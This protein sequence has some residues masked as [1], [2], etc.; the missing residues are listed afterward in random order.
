MALVEILMR[1]NPFYRNYTHN[2]KSLSDL[3][4]KL[5][6]RIDDIQSISSNNLSFIQRILVFLYA[7]FVRIFSSDIKYY[8]NYKK[9]VVSYLQKSKH[10]V[11]K[12]FLQ[13]LNIVGKKLENRYT[14]I[15]D[16]T[17]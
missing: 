9:N 4:N 3:I 14:R 8:R 11:N 16:E 17:L 2:A 12:K 5:R 10:P 13:L 1:P 6:L 7:P 15:K